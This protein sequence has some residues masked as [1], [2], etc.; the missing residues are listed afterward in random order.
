MHALSPARSSP[1]QAHLQPWCGHRPVRPAHPT[2]Q[3]PKRI[4]IRHATIGEADSLL[5]PPSGRGLHHHPAAISNFYPPCPNPL[6][7]AA[8]TSRRRLRC[9]TSTLTHL[10]QPCRPMHPQNSKLGHD[11]EKQYQKKKKVMPT[12]HEAFR[13]RW[14]AFSSDFH[15]CVLRLDTEASAHGVPKLKDGK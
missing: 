10:L 2:T 8:R 6:S 13:N 3:Q 1:K 5:P 4:R 11:T 14:A 12:A 15:Y 9:T 7:L